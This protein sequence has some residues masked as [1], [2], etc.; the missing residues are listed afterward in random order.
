MDWELI[1]SS[2]AAH[3]KAPKVPKVRKPFL[4][5][6]EFEAML[7]LCPLNTR[8]GARRQSMLWLMVTTG[9][10]KREMWLLEKDDLDW[11]RS[12]IRVRYGKGQKE[13]QIPFDQRCQ[14]AVLRYLHHRTDLLPCLWVTD[15]GTKLAQDSIFQDIRRVAQRVGV[16]LKD[17]CHIF[18]R[19]FAANAVRQHIPRPYVQAIAGWSTPQMLD[20][21][22]AAMEAE[23]GA[24]EA[25]REFKPFG[26]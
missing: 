8:A 11:D 15:S 2:P 5:Q 6:G 25:F 3:M 13:R 24:I 12:I 17:T 1:E 7:N 26:A 10:R 4:S 23:E 18:R 9:I 16:E 22:V 19:T 14:R 21:Y 20:H